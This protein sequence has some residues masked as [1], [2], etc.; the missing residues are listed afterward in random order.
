ME[1]FSTKTEDGFTQL[2]NLGTKAE[3]THVKGKNE[4]FWT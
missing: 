3:L 4:S 1:S 2:R